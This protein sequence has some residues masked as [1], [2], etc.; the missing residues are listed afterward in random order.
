MPKLVFESQGGW[1]FYL[2]YLLNDLTWHTY[3][4]LM[5]IRM[6]TFTYHL[7]LIA[8]MFDWNWIPL[9]YCSLVEFD[10][11]IAI[12]IAKMEKFVGIFAENLNETKLIHK[13][14]KGLL[15]RLNAIEDAYESG[16]VFTSLYLFTILW[17]CDDCELHSIIILVVTCELHCVAFTNWHEFWIIVFRVLRNKY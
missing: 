17:C 12:R 15:Y 2:T 11:N 5:I 14:F 7:S 8:T 10:K 3:E 16:F 1:K 6:N 13:G 9:A 4:P